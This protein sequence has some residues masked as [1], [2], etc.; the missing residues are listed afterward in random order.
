MSKAELGSFV[1][2]RLRAILALFVV[3]F[4]VFI[5]GWNMGRQ[6]YAYG[7]YVGVEPLLYPCPYVDAPQNQTPCPYNPDEP[8]P[9]VAVWWHGW[10]G[11]VPAMPILEPTAQ[12]LRDI[13]FFKLPPAPHP[14]Q[15]DRHDP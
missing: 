14:Q 3:F 15:Q 13:V 11:Q 5:I 4:I 1:S 9:D 7:L 6:Q 2:R 12:C 8:A 10:P